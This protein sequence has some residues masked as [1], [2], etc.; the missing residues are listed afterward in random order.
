MSEAATKTPVTKVLPSRVPDGWWTGHTRY[1]NYVLFAGTGVVLAL[2][3]VVL[4]IAVSAVGQ[5]SEAW[6]EFLGAVGSVPGLIVMV[7]LFIGTAFFGFRWMRVGAKLA[8]VKL[9]PL[10]AISP[11]I[12]LIAQM[13]GLFALFGVVLFLL[14]GAIGI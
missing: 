4:L 12:A 14:S 11:T 1:R 5:G 7:F 2:V 6:G 10:P 8:A 3:N 13:G 9:G